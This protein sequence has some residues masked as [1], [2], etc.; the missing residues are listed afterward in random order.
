MIRPLSL[1]RG[2]GGAFEGLLPTQIVSSPSEVVRPEVWL[3]GQDEDGQVGTKR[4]KPEDGVAKLRQADVSIAQ[5]QSVADVIQ[6]FGVTEVTY[7]V[8]LRSSA[9]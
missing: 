5:G 4:H 1:L 8:G 9:V 6:S 7:S 2:D 3:E